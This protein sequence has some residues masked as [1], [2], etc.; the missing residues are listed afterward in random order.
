MNALCYECL[1]FRAALAPALVDSWPCESDAQS[2]SG[3]GMSSPNLKLLRLSQMLV[4][5]SL[6]D[7]IFAKAKLQDVKTVK[8]WL[9][10][11][12]LLEYELEEAQSLLVSLTGQ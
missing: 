11:G 6:S 8:L 2:C 3:L 5:Y 1:L 4:D 9:G 7:Q 12:I 10:A